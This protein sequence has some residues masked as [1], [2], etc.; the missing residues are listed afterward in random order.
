MHNRNYLS[1]AHLYGLPLKDTSL[2]SV[3]FY[4]VRDKIQSIVKQ[5]RLMA[6]TD[7]IVYFFLFKFLLNKLH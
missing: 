7:Y 4:L 6:S 1:A 5:I 2:F 3:P